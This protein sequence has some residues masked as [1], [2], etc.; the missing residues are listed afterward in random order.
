MKTT[1]G[2]FGLNLLIWAGSGLLAASAILHYLLWS[3]EGYRHIPT[4][5]PLFLAQAIIGLL[6]A[7]LAAVFRRLI[8]VAAASGL[9]A[10]SVGALL[11]SIQWGLFGWQESSGAPYVGMA[12]A[13]EAIG[14]VLL[15]A[16]CV[17]LASPW[18]SEARS[19]RATGSGR[20]EP[21]PRRML[22]FAPS[23]GTGETDRSSHPAAGR[24]ASTSLS[25]RAN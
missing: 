16:A 24:R 3:S 11:I 8:L 25:E 6:L 2:R 13:I 20:A 17:L 19:R 14:A 12:L 23:G 22:P 15:G 9:V 18:L 21:P 10:S 4:I 5:G 7:I 1:T